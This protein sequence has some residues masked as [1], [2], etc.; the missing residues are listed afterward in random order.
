MENLI[1][2]NSKILN[3]NSNNNISCPFSFNKNIDI[4]DK[5]DESNLYI[6]IKQAIE[7]MKEYYNNCYMGDKSKIKS[8]LFYF[9]N[10]SF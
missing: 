4:L 2:S 6:K 1:L 8:K 10:F 3:V 7:S 5:L 9:I